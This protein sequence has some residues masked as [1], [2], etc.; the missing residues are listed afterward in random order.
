MN[1]ISD[2]GLRAPAGK[3]TISDDLIKIGV[4]KP[5]GKALGKYGIGNSQT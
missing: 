4:G 1:L 3:L 5:T 2:G